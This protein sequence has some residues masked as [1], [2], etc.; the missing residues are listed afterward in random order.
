MAN[1]D[2]SYLDRLTKSR[3]ASRGGL[4][5]AR[6]RAPGPAAPH[7]EIEPR[8]GHTRE[9]QETGFASDIELRWADELREQAIS[10]QLYSCCE[11]TTKPGSAWEELVILFSNR[12]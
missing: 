5:S 3:D 10:W 11:R 2:V 9:R 1:D 7:A 8:P 12:V 6:R 4:E